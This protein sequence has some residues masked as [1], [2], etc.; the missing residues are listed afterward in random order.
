MRRTVLLFA[1]AIAALVVASG[2]ALAAVSSSPD[3]GTINTDGRVSTILVS[4]GKVYLGGSFTHV[5]GVARNHLAAIDASTGQLTNWNPNANSNVLALAASPDASRIYAGGSF[6]EVGGATHRRLVS[7]DAST[8]AVNTQFK[9]GLGASVRAIAVSGSGLYIGGD[10]TSVKGQSRS[11][12]AL[13]DATTAALDPNWAPAADKGVRALVLS[14]D[15]SRIYA[16]GDFTSISGE[17]K[18]Y[19]A[20]LDAAGAGAVEWVPRVNPN[21]RV[22]DI[23]AQGSSVY[24]AEGGRGGAAAAYDSGSGEVLW[25][26]KG[27]G[28]P[29]SVA[30]VD[31]KVYLGGHFLKIEGQARRFFA[32][33]DAATGALEAWNPSGSGAGAGVWALEANPLGTRLYAGGDFV[34]VSGATHEHFAQFSS[35]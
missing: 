23:V 10:F 6:T 31:G 26:N 30:V 19:L 20:G 22:Y 18:R 27:D 11:R 28:D 7:L 2:A 34:K 33:V 15:G 12:L 1:T 35:R 5:D 29:Q 32:A 4:G 3:P 14:P 25:S 13:I 8:G 17:S 21:G 16:G 9:I 24:S